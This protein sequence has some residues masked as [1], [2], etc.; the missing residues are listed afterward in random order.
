[1]KTVLIDWRD[2]H[3]PNDHESEITHSIGGYLD[4]GPLITVP[5]DSFRGPG[6]RHLTATIFNDVLDYLAHLAKYQEG[7]GA[8]RFIG[9]VRRAPD[10]ATALQALA[11][12]QQAMNPGSD[13]IPRIRTSRKEH[14]SFDYCVK[15]V[16]YDPAAAENIQIESMGEGMN[17]LLDSHPVLKTLIGSEDWDEGEEDDDGW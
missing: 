16:I 12:I 17:D 2:A 15:T 14:Q 3:H 13:G 10:K 6:R 7:I 11:M 1:M 5:V 9:I 8:E 4:E